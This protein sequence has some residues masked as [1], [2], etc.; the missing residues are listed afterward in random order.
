MCSEWTEPL[1]KS[2]KDGGKKMQILMEG[3]AKEHSTQVWGD[4]GVEAIKARAREWAGAG[5]ETEVYWKRKPLC[6]EIVKDPGNE[7]IEKN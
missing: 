1:T 6:N 2:P 3:Q 7:H 4:R 5:W